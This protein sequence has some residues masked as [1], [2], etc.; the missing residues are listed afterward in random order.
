MTALVF[1]IDFETTDTNT[2]TC[3]I[4]EVGFAFYCHEQ[5]LIFNEQSCLI[6]GSELDLKISNIRWESR[7]YHGLF[8]DDVVVAIQQ[9][10]S[11][12]NYI[13]A[14]NAEFEQALLR[15]LGVNTT[16]KIWIDTLYD[17]PP[18]DRRPND[19]ERSSLFHRVPNLRAHRA[20][21]DVVAMLEILNQYPFTEVHA[22][23]MSPTVTVVATV[24][25]DS[26]HLAKECGFMWH[27]DAK[28]WA[29]KVKA[30][31][32]MQLEASWPFKWSVLGE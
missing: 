7:L 2:E 12:V 30:C 19:L 13:C 14:H 11:N 22:R 1:G 10:I 31:D 32:L 4:G 9:A 23:A 27:P 25:Y 24:S 29:K 18:D 16:D 28:Q 21:P 15:R 5:R 8:L 6:R 26:R 17:L 3:E 20:L